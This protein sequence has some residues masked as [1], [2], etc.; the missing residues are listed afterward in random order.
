MVN[1]NELRERFSKEWEKHYA[2]DVLKE[3][4]YQRHKCK[5][6]GKHFWSLDDR[7]VCAD[8][9]CVGYEFIGNPPSN[10]KLGYVETWEKIKHY[11]TTHGHT[12]VEPYPTVARWRDDLYFTIAS[13]SDFQPYVVNGE[14]EPPGNPLIVP[15]PCIRF[16]DISNV[17]CTGRHYTNFVMIGQHAFNTDKTGLFYWKNE[18]IEHDINYVNSLGV[19]EEDLVFIEDVWAGAG[20]FGPCLE[21]FSRGLELGNCVFMQYEIKG[22]VERELKTKVIDMGAGLSRLCW[23]THGTPTSYE[24]VFE[25]AIENL[26]RS[27]GV[28]VDEDLFLNYAK[29]S[30]KL[31]IDE[32]EDI[33]KERQNVAAQ[34]NV[35][36]EVLAEQLEP[37]QALYAIADHTLT[38]LFTTIDGMLPSNSGGGYN[39]R[40]LTRRMCAFEERYGFEIDYARVL[41]DH[42]TMLYP[43][44]P[45]LKEGV[46]CTANVIAVEKKKYAE[47]KKNAANKIRAVIKKAKKQGTGITFETL[48]MLYTSHGIDPTTVKQ[49]GSKEGVVVDVPGDFYEKV[50]VADEIDENTG[51][52]QGLD[53]SNYPK[54][55]PLY[56]ENIDEFEAMVLGNVSVNG[57]TYVILDKT[58]FY[59]EGGGQVGDRG[60]LATPELAVEVTNVKK[61]DGVVLHKVEKPLPLGKVVGKVD[62]DRRKRVSAHHTAAHILLASAREVLG[63]HVWQAGSYKDVDK[64]HFDISHYQ[65]ITDE[66]LNKIEKL[67]NAHIMEN[68]RI[69]TEVLP[70]T[71]AEQKYGFCLYQGGAIPSKELRVVVIEGIDVEACGG[72]HQVHR[73]TGELGPFKIHKR[74]SVQD[75]VER[76]T[77]SVGLAAV[78][79]IQ[80]QEE[81]LKNASA[82]LSVS[83]QEL[84][85]AVKR[86]FEEWKLQKKQIATLSQ[87]LADSIV[88]EI[89]RSSEEVP[90][91][92]VPLE[93]KGLQM[94]AT[95]LNKHNL[96]GFIYNKEGNMV[97]VGN[98]KISANEVLEHAKQMFEVKGGGKGNTI[99]GKIIRKKH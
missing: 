21:Y 78:E 32:V 82:V 90:I 4:G 11:F 13:I 14:L 89:K 35:P 16:G 8:P 59:P 73:T 44:F 85:N 31:N 39:L 54:T 15:Q 17:G 3:R 20:N 55:E 97:C 12:Y 33:E 48:K 52:K 49:L 79:Y 29:L 65:R 47:T 38:L 66:E 62:W 53:V 60:A 56:Y 42:A 96:C 22:G 83:P 34:L 80:K 86:F 75:G 1:K 19:K 43:M 95:M 93:M 24:L 57:E 46:E 61:V 99:F 87:R 71:K 37:L 77:F 18:A 2:L 81:H 94:I 6:C 58:A 30:G 41:E 28:E 64:A 36:V 10:Q 67:V 98:D 69:T 7:D 25:K 5:K 23:I 68:K 40:I 72:T 51:Q 74:E 84:P 27:T 9:Q 92:E 91:V 88:E 63:P 50:R 70:R 26:K 45:R 76:I